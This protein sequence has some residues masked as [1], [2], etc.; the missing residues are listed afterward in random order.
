MSAFDVTPVGVSGPRPNSAGDG[1]TANYRA[2][3]LHEQEAVLSAIRPF[4]IHIRNDDNMLLAYK[5][6]TRHPERYIIDHRKGMVLKTSEVVVSIMLKPPLV[7]ERS[8]T[9]ADDGNGGPETDGPSGAAAG[10]DGNTAADKG[11][12]GPRPISFRVDRPV[13]PPSPTKRYSSPVSYRTTA[14]P[15]S[16]GVGMARFGVPVT[17]KQ[18]QG[19]DGDGGNVADEA[20]QTGPEGSPATGNPPAATTSVATGLGTRGSSITGSRKSLSTARSAMLPYY[21]PPAN[22]SPEDV[23]QVELRAVLAESLR[24]DPALSP[25]KATDA[26]T[27]SPLS[28]NSNRASLEIRENRLAQRKKEIQLLNS[29]NAEFDKLW[30]HAISLP[31]HVVPCQITFH[32]AVEYLNHSIELAANKVSQLQLEQASYKKQG[33][34]LQQRLKEID[35]TNKAFEQEVEQLELEYARISGAIPSARVPIWI[36]FLAILCSILLPVL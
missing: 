11:G 34:R 16:G 17:G 30:P 36:A 14:Q 24:H 4:R 29:L 2:Q 26:S 20:S 5:I 10:G 15:A 22:V 31:T 3:V 19:G 35:K 13:P 27:F 7:P 9:S 33:E 18:T 8:S 32:T 28:P 25:S 12:P 1:S 6:S 23:F 21:I